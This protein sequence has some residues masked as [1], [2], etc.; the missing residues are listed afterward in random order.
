[1]S[2]KKTQNQKRHKS[3]NYLQVYKTQKNTIIEKITQK[4]CFNQ[5]KLKFHFSSIKLCDQTHTHNNMLG[6]LCC[7][8][9]LAKSE[10]MSHAKNEYL[11]KINSFLIFYF[12]NQKT[13]SRSQCF[14]ANI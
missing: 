8:T 4:K 7:K 1:M 11:T 3:A 9:W 5:Q 14:E 12:F 6:K 2:C 13:T 10:K